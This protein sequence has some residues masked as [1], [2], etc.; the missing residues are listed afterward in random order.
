MHQL[1]V[2]R[3][4]DHRQAQPFAQIVEQVQY[5]ALHGHIEP[6][7]RLIRDK[8]RIAII[9]AMTMAMRCLIPPE[10]SCA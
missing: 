4:E 5:P 10:N 7:G 1:Q 9:S 3:D 6:G 8:Q 2:M